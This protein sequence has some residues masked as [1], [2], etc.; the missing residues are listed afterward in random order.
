MGIFSGP[1][2]M[3]ETLKVKA[4]PQDMVLSSH[5]LIP[6]ENV[7]WCSPDLLFAAMDSLPRHRQNGDNIC[8]LP[9]IIDLSEVVMNPNIV[10]SNVHW[11]NIDRSNQAGKTAKSRRSQQQTLQFNTNW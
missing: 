10:P 4:A 3:I 2:G 7:V 5:K 1:S 9:G 8:N 11:Q 6:L